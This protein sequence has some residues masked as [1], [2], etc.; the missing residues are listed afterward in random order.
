[1]NTDKHISAEQA[2]N[3]VMGESSD[4]QFKQIENHLTHCEPCNKLVESQL[5]NI[6]A[7]LELGQMDFQL[8]E[9]R[10]SDINRQLISHSKFFSKI[11]KIAAVFVIL[12][13]ITI[14]TIGNDITKPTFSFTAAID[15]SDVIQTHIL[16]IK[17]TDKLSTDTEGNTTTVVIDTN[18]V[19][20]AQ[21]SLK[22]IKQ[23]LAEM[24]Q[25]MAVN[26][27]INLII[28]GTRESSF[29][30]QLETNNLSELIA[31]INK[32]RLATR[33]DL[34][35][36]VEYGY[37]YASANY[38]WGKTNNFGIISENSVDLILD[39][40]TINPNKRIN[41]LAAN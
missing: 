25:K 24:T 12:L 1:M 22:L 3:F 10:R 4:Q 36:S 7:T 30:E 16:E 39:E 31:E 27:S 6:E 34:A 32:V 41:V 33:I 17:R 28:T 15:N 18:S 29:T 2:M 26:D 21:K 20:S 5:E 11:T 37:D 23:H 35:T 40:I 14:A 13:G 38:H 19:Q 8:T 9:K